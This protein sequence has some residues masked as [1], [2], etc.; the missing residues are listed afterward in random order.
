VIGQTISHYRIIEKLGGGGMGVVYKAED[1][2]LGRFVALKFLPEDVAQDSQALERFRREARAASALNHPNICTIYEIGRHDE[3]SFIAMEFLDGL[4]LKHRIAGRPMETELILSLAIEIADALD[5]AH[6]EGIVHRDIKPANLF[7]TKRGHAKILDFG[8][9]KVAPVESPTQIAENGAETRTI[10]APH[11]TTPGL[12]LGT[13]AYMS[14]EQARAKELDAR[15]DLFSFGTVLYEMATGQLPFRGDSTATI[16]DSILNRN[17]VPAVRLN[18]DLPGTLEDII[19]KALEKNR[20]LRYQVAAEMRADLQR[21]KRDMDSGRTAPLAIARQTRNA[22][23][24]WLASAVVALVLLVAGG[25]YWRPRGATKLTEKDTIVLADFVNATGDPVFDDTLKQALSI[26]LQQTPFLNILSDKKINDTLALMGRATGERLNEA[27]AR[28]V[29]QRTESAAVL[30]GSISGLGSEYVLGLKA[31]NCR[32]G[33]ALDQEQVQ[34]AKKEEVLRA[35]DQVTAKLRTGLGESLSMVQKFDTPIAEATTSSLEALKAYSLGMRAFR[36][37]GAG[38]GIPFLKRAVGL[39]PN[40]ALAY[41]ALGIAYGPNLGEPRLAAENLQKAYQLRDRV[42]E[43]EKFN[44]TSAYE[45]N[46]TGDL[47]KSIQGDELWASTYPRDPA[48]LT[49]LGYERQ[50]LGQYERSAVEER[51]AIRA[52]PNNASDF[53]NLMVDYLALDRLDEARVIYRQALDRKLD[54]PYLHDDMYALAFL[55]GDAEEMQRQVAWAASKAGAEDLLLSAQSDTE[56]LHGHL[57]K[58]RE[59]SRRAVESA[60]RSD[61]KETA[62]QW[63]LNSALREAELGNSEQARRQVKAALAIISSRDAQILAALTLARVGD[64]A[65]AQVMSEELAKKFPANTLLHNYWLPTILGYTEIRR[66]SP[67]QAL[68]NL[69]AAAP[70][71]LAF[72]QPQFEE[73]GLLY[74]AYVRGQVYLLLRQGKEA[75][76]EFQK[77]LEHRGVVIN[78]PLGALAHYQIAR[79]LA[80]S[81]DAV[82]AHKAYEDFFA[83]W[84]DADPDIPILKQAKAEY[85]KLQ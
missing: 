12:T 37:N 39:D 27:T 42:S 70:Y 28:E 54:D 60:L 1:T 55:E 25:L 61:Q 84:K 14:P 57:E 10:D 77:L 5:A 74:P 63:Q 15:T 82:G 41:V 20:N 48:A 81:S 58:A 79:A 71:D 30:A 24:K 13:V 43:R 4:T 31:V 18:P 62:A 29:C 65:R 23:W 72:P 69:E 47:E 19:S 44:I 8:L 59:L 45:I 17:P 64:I 53:G 67:T 51:K 76:V 16:F 21:L 78:S 35:L 80:L 75:T 11:L 66:G 9:A 34:V 46:V 6:S 32:S 26:G 52:N 73:G 68:K 33:D 85:A 40:F 3:Q 50:L 7:V 56:A 38:E 2:E 36:E 83:L 49:N 22:R